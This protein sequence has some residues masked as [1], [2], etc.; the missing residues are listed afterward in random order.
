M[1][2]AYSGNL[3]LFS[4]NSQILSCSR[5]VNY[6]QFYQ[7]IARLNIY[8]LHPWIAWCEVHT[9]IWYD[10]R[11]LLSA[12]WI[13][14]RKRVWKSYSLKSYRRYENRW[15]ELH[16]L[17]VWSSCI[18]LFLLCTNNT[19]FIDDLLTYFYS[20][21]MAT[22]SAILAPNRY[23]SGVQSGS[24]PTSTKYSCWNIW[25]WISLC[26][27]RKTMASDNKWSQFY[28]TNVWRW[29]LP[30]VVVV[31]HLRYPKNWLENCFLSTACS[32]NMLSC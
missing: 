24:R 30:G 8:Y 21:L 7:A 4:S 25:S 32:Q 3:A 14:H 13:T 20:V 29:L 11:I 12:V 5:L 16:T 1:F 31:V 27:A 6:W 18:L 15:D 22:T 2:Q 17:L 19:D 26:R 28:L 9:P 23:S 10:E